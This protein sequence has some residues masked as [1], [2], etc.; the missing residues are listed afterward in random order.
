MDQEQA[1]ARET[2]KHIARVKTNIIEM[3]SHFGSWES[4]NVPIF[5]DKNSNDNPC[6]NQEFFISLKM[7]QA[8]IL[9]MSLHLPFEDVN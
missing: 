6:P 8:Q 5:W 3:T 4:W 9:K 7:S 1:K 2:P